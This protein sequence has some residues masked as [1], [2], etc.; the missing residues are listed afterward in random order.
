MMKWKSASYCIGERRKR[1]GSSVE[2]G[3]GEGEEGDG[4]MEGAGK[5]GSEGYLATQ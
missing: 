2:P 1:G 4:R 5:E 3:W